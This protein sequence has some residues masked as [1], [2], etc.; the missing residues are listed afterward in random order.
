MATDQPIPSRRRGGVLL[1]A[2]LLLAVIGVV[3][4]GGIAVVSS[5]ADADADDQE[6]YTVERRSFDITS[7]ANGELKARRETKV[8]SPVE[9]TTTIIDIVPE[10]T[11][12]DEGEVLCRLATEEIERRLYEEEEKLRTAVNNVNVAENALLIQKSDN[13][14]SFRQAK[15]KVELAE[16]EL[17]KWEFGDVVER[18]KD[19]ELALERAQRQVDRL[20]KLVA[21]SRELHAQDFL[22][23]D[24]LELDELEL[25]EAEASLEKARL[26]S[27]VYEE[28]TYHKERKNLS[29]NLAEAKAELDRVQSRNESQLK[30]KESDLAYKQ[31]NLRK[32]QQEVEE[33]REELD[34]ATI[35]APTSGLVVF[36]TSLQPEWRFDS[37]GPIQVGREVRKNEDIIVLPEIS[38][39]I[40][41]VKVHESLVGKIRKGQ[42]ALVTI[43]A[44]E[45]QVFEGRIDAI[46]ILAE[47]GGWRDPNLR[48]YE[49]KIGLDVDSKRHKLKPSMRCE[50]EI[51]LDQAQSVLAVPIPAIFIDEDVNYVHT[52]AD[53]KF[54]RTPVI[55]GRR[56]DLYAEIIAGLE[57]GDDVLVAEPPTA[58]IID[59]PFDEARLEALA[60]AVPQ[61]AAPPA[62]VTE[63]TPV[64]AEPDDQDA[65]A[66]DTDSPDADDVA[67][68]AASDETTPAPLPTAASG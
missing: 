2:V 34:A 58:R 39:M 60:A 59:V 31:A 56:S 67:D 66:S 45:G 49:V 30:T 43:D 33:L 18:R 26:Q 65:A 5:D 64:A 68:T 52:P 6:T 23:S 32:R 40:A 21:R 22:S 38:D 1:K 48:E 16:I 55:I 10:G 54:A 29:S 25:V 27:K 8:V 37:R 62:A 51:I 13:D 14:S 36:A 44:A 57:P 17:R 61:P 47:S 63:P 50:A 15:L 3:G 12:I 4:G 46:G 35:K 11:F 42:R 19:L 53:G 20:T 41:S 28:F 24:K 7:T 9:R